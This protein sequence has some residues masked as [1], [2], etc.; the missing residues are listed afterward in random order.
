MKK[1]EI[2]FKAWMFVILA[3]V[4]LGI[5][6]FGSGDVSGQEE[7]GENE[8]VIMENNELLVVEIV[9]K[10]PGPPK[11]IEDPKIAL[12]AVRRGE[13]D[14]IASEGETKYEFA[15]PVREVEIFQRKKIIYKDGKWDSK[16]VVPLI[17]KKG[18]SLFTTGIAIILPFLGIFILTFLNLRER[19]SKNN[20]F[21]LYFLAIG[22]AVVG[23][24]SGR[25]FNAYITSVDLFSILIGLLGGYFIGKNV[26]RSELLG[27][28]AGALIG[29]CV[30]ANI[31]I[32]TDRGVFSFFIA[33]VCFASYWFCHF[34]F[35]FVPRLCVVETEKVNNTGN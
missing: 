29:L 12:Q 28:V 1:V 11:W 16:V 2:I 5:L 3:L 26:V 6:F 8:R 21:H 9:E 15:F 34:L 20:L 14:F 35:L 4:L 24:I 32:F 22:I 33:S 25:I 7:L 27:F 10:Y 13:A 19:G 30:G 18:N 31:V 17:K 23:A